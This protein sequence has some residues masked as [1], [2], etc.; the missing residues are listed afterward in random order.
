MVAIAAEDVLDVHHWNDTLFSFRTTREA[1]LRFRNGQFVMVGLEH[2]GK[3][4]L[5]AYSIASANHEDFLARRPPD[6][7]AAASAPGGQGADQSQTHRD[8]GAG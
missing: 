5:R 7:P 8:P 1:S 4:L 3:P 2:S 6:R